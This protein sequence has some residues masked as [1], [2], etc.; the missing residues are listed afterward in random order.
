MPS[1]AATQLDAHPG[2]DLDAAWALDP[3]GT[4]TSLVP[5]PSIRLL[6]TCPVQPKR[7]SLDGSA[8]SKDR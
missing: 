8:H 4:E 5:N 2:P 6:E 3:V 1:D 7:R